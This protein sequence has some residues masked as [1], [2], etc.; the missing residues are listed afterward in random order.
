MKVY[1]SSLVALCKI[2]VIG[3]VQVIGRVTGRAD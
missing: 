1:P 2:T 3:A